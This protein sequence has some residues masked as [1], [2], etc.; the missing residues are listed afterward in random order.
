MPWVFCNVGNLIK[1]PWPYNPQICLGFLIRNP[2]KDPRFLIQVPILHDEST[3]SFA[4]EGLDALS[5][6]PRGV[7]AAVDRRHGKGLNNMK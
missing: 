4:Q 5:A 3:G 7:G 6:L 2:N 1:K